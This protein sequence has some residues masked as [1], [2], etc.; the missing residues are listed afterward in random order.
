P[1]HAEEVSRGLPTTVVAASQDWELARWIQQCFSRESFRVYTNQDLLGVELGGALK[2]IIGIAAGIG[3]GL[4]FGDNSKSAL[5][6]RGVV[7]ITRF[8]IALGAEHQT[9]FGLAGLG[10]L[11][12]TCVSPH[13]R[14]RQV[15]QRL[16]RGEK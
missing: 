1:S 14:N 13:G 11:I 2:N 6:T 10:D 7:E 8:G 4:G 15:G 16:G 3:D 12:T 5:L 9:F